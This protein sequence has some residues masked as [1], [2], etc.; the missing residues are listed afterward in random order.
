MKKIKAALSPETTQV[1]HRYR[2]S[3]SSS[4]SSNSD[5]CGEEIP[6]ISKKYYRED[7]IEIG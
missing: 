3:E 7:K 1:E 5:I 4:S 2:T 6:I